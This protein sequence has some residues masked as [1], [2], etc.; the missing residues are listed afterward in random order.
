MYA[1]FA[2]KVFSNLGQSNRAPLAQACMHIRAELECVRVCV[3]V[4]KRETRVIRDV[5]TALWCRRECT[6]E[7]AHSRS[8]CRCCRCVCVGVS[9]FVC[10]HARTG[11]E[12]KLVSAVFRM[13]AHALHLNRLEPSRAFLHSSIVRRTYH[14]IRAQRIRRRMAD[15]TALRPKHSVQK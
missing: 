1:C 8:P 7:H 10:A 12:H 14:W 2:P 15:T 11:C 9:V 5:R 3:R 4:R 6:R 13:D